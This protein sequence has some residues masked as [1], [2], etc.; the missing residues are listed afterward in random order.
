MLSVA[1]EFEREFNC[2]GSSG[3]PLFIDRS[4][5]AMSVRRG[6]QT[7]EKRDPQPAQGDN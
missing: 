7:I 3:V 6:R 1:D 4:P 2:R 5:D